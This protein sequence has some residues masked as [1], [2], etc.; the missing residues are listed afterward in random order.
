MSRR[1]RIVVVGA[2]VIGCAIAHELASRGAAVQVVDPRPAGMGATQAS[3]GI[4]APFIEAPAGWPL[5]DLTARSLELYDEFVTRVSQESGI[6][7]SYRRTGTLQVAADADR[8]NE[9][10][11][12][13]AALETR[14]IAATVL[15]AREAQAAE[16]HLDGELAGALLIAAHGFVGAGELTRALVA[17]ARRREAQFVEG[18][19]VDRITPQSGGDLSVETDRGAVTGEAVVMAAGCW[20]G[21]IEVAGAA[22]RIPVRPI[23]GQLLHL[24]WS[25]RPLARVTW[26]DRCYLVPWED[27]TTLVGATVEDAGFDERTTV[28]GVRDLLDAAC[29]LVPHAWTATLLGARAGLRPVS[30]DELPIIG[31]SR[32]VPNLVYA[33]GHYRNGVLL[34]PVTAKLVAD[35]VLESRADPMLE[36]FAPRRF[37][38]V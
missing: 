32:V 8:L 13:A 10:R 11:D 5:L 12:M 25:G 27:G 20:S 34:A 38:E 24:S 23:R 33:T 14:D 9:F 1:A 2:G 4:L 7:V 31:R 29:E 36:P 30:G 17:A 35:A 28:A 16:P 19:R 18:A 15:G 26:S 3:A 22:I 6:A 21:Q 37:G